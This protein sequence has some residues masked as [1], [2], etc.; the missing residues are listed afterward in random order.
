MSDELAYIDEVASSFKVAVIQDLEG[1][2]RN[3]SENPTDPIERE[4][5]AVKMAQKIL[6][7][8]NECKADEF[9]LNKRDGE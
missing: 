8:I 9:L 4:T 6:D 2:L 1:W 7:A 5:F 3:M